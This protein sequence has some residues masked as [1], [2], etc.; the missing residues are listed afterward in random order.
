MYSAYFIPIIYF[1]Q[2]I[3]FMLYFEPYYRISIIAVCILH[4]LDGLIG[5]ILWIEPRQNIAFWIIRK[6]FSMISQCNYIY[7]LNFYQSKQFTG[8]GHQIIASSVPSQPSSHGWFGWY[9]R[10]LISQFHP[11]MYWNTAECH[12]CGFP[13]PNASRNTYVNSL[14]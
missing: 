14:K 3:W 2:V 11:S 9:R 1:F 6:V 5:L 12:P 4:I 8:L 13:D 7:S 10:Q